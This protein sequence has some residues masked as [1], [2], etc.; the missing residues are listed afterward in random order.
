M[1]DIRF[2]FEFSVQVSFAVPR[3]RREIWRSLSSQNA[4]AHHSGGRMTRF[5][6]KFLR[7]HYILCFAVVVA[8]ETDL[9]LRREFLVHMLN[10]WR[11]GFLLKA[12]IC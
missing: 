8:F 5:Y 12:P 7:F 9:C 6:H 3:H 10:A 1:K 4:A 2:L 11:R